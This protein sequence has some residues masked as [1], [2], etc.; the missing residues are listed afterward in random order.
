ME[1]LR[2]VEN[3]KSQ[4][5]VNRVE[6]NVDFYGSKYTAIVVVPHLARCH[7]HDDKS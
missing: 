3:S 2:I 1:C 4:Q 6:Y 7:H 5:T